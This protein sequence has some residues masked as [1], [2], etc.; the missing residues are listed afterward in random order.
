MRGH[1]DLQIFVHDKKFFCHRGLPTSFINSLNFL[2]EVKRSETVLTQEYPGDIAFNVACTGTTA[3][4]HT[5][6]TDKLIQGYLKDHSIKLV[7]ISQGYSKCSTCIAGPRHII[8]ADAGIHK[9]AISNDIESLL[10]NPGNVSLPG[11]R[12]G[13]IG[14]ASGLLY[15]QLFF[16]GSLE[17][18][19]DGAAIRSFLKTAGVEPVC[20]SDDP[21]ID[22]GSLFFI[23]P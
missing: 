23:C 13:F 19:P 14:G 2:G 8:T 22:L 7:H 10:V 6:Y 1:P 11:Y 9:A 20:L 17:H 3:F 15:D 16:T 21:L 5:A 18:H 4:H 12:Y